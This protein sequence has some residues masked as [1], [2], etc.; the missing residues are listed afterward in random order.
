MPWFVSAVD[1][2]LMGLRTPRRPGSHGD[3]DL[4]DMGD[5]TRCDVCARSLRR[6]AS[7]LDHGSFDASDDEVANTRFYPDIAGGLLK[8]HPGRSNR[9]TTRVRSVLRLMARESRPLASLALVNSGHQPAVIDSVTLVEPTRLSIIE[10]WIL[11]YPEPLDDGRVPLW[12]T[13]PSTEHSTHTS[14]RT[15]SNS[16]CPRRPTLGRLGSVL[17]AFCQSHLSSEPACNRVGW[18]RATPVIQS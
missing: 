4:S 12:G 8:A 10:S 15:A 2:S 14:P 1:A 7:L 11:T 17:D 3:R 18:V 9:S 13:T 5:S 16:T 6:L